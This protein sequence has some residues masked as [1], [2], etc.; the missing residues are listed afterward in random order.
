[1]LYM[2]DFNRVY[3]KAKERILVALSDGPMTR[4]EIVRATGIKRTQCYYYL[5]QLLEGG[6]VEK[7]PL[8]DYIPTGD[9]CV[10]CVKSRENGS[11]KVKDPKNCV[12]TFKMKDRAHRGRPPVL[13]QLKGEA[14]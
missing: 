12:D 3:F 14:P 10:D 5:K 6:K 1:M 9:R 11:C 7:R 4:P 2:N 13:Y 8:H